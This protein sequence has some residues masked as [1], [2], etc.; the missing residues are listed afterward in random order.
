MSY[1]PISVFTNAFASAA[2]LSPAYDLGRAWKTLYLDVPTMNSGADIY[3]QVS[4]DNSTYRRLQIQKDVIQ[5]FSVSVASSVTLASSIDLGEGAY[6]PYLLIPTLATGTSILIQGS[7]DDSTFRRVQLIE[8]SA[9]V[10][11]DYSVATFAANVSR[12]AQIPSGF[13]Y[14][15]VELAT[16]VTQVTNTFKVLASKKDARVD[17][18]IASNVTNRVVPIPAGFRYVKVETDATVDNGNTFKII[19]SD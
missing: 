10:T 14:I 1:G 8:G 16:G 3:L 5:S 7:L 9:A 19:C 18:N 2:T 6:N 12:F 15:K 17:F 4:H 13:R 11:A